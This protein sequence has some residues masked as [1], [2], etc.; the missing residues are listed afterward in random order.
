MS[1]TVVVMHVTLYTFKFMLN[2]TCSHYIAIVSCSHTVIL[3]RICPPKRQSACMRTKGL[4]L[5][6]ESKCTLQLAMSQM[7]KSEAVRLL[8][9]QKR[10]QQ[11]H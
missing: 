11:L 8:T 10:Y 9:C 3:L 6:W 1:C 5:L 4:F 7:L 2:C